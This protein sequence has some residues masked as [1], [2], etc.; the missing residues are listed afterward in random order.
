[1]RIPKTLLLHQE[2]IPFSLKVLSVPV[3]YFLSLE[4]PFLIFL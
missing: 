3:V 4:L 1:M 2:G